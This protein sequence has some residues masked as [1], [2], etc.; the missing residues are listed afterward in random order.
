[1]FFSKKL[2][3]FKN[4]NHCFFSKKGGYSSGIYESLNCG[5]GSDDNKNNVIKNLEFVAKKMEINN[6]ENLKL[7]NQTHSNKV[8][9]L[10]EKNKNSNKIKSDSLVTNING[11]ALGVLTADCVP[12]ILY[13]EINKSIGC[14]HAGWKGSI[15]GIIENTVKK[16][17]EINNKVKITACIG[18][19]IGKKNYE[20]GE[21]FYKNFLAESKNNINFFLKQNHNKY[22]FDI[23]KY[24]NFKLNNCGVEEV[25]NIDFDT[26]EDKDNFYSYRRSQKLGQTDYGRCIATISLKT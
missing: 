19:C 25:E 20:V 24:V 6:L 23:R 17:K 16:F 13:D 8:F 7:M 2:K 10:D 18:P 26:F 9:F 14:I 3:K 22:N 4:I 21:D 5:L 1:M 12:I 15:S 11:V